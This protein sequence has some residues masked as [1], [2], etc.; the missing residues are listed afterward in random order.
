MGPFFIVVV[1]IFL[2]MNLRIVKPV[3]ITGDSGEEKSLDISKKKEK[4]N[5]K[6]KIESQN[7]KNFTLN[8][9]DNE[10]SVTFN[11]LIFL[12]SRLIKLQSK[13]NSKNINDI[14]NVSFLNDKVILKFKNESS[15]KKGTFIITFLEGSVQDRNGN[16]IDDFSIIFSTNNILNKHVLKGKVLDLMT[17]Q[18]LKN[19]YVF[20]YKVSEDDLKNKVSSR[21][22][23]NN[24]K[25]EYFSKTDIL[26]NYSF[27]N[28]SKGIYFLC[29]GEIDKEN[30]MSDPNKHKYGFSPR[31]IKID[32]KNNAIEQ[33]IFILNSLLNEFTILN[34]SI[35]NNK[36]IIETNDF[37]SEFN[38]DIKDNLL[39][40]Y[41]KYSEL[42]KKSVQISDNKKI[43]IDNNI[44]NLIS[45]DFLPC[46]LTI[47]SIN[48][49][50]I[51]KDIILK[52]NNSAFN[53]TDDDDDD[54]DDFYNEP[55][56]N[57]NSQEFE[58]KALSQDLSID[59]LF[60]FN[61]I[62]KKNVFAT[63]KTKF[64]IIISD[65]YGLVKTPFTDF[66]IIEEYN[67]IHI[68]TNK[69]LQDI[70]NDI[71]NN[72]DKFNVLSKNDINVVIFVD[73]DA[74]TYSDFTKNKDNISTFSFLRSFSSL[75]VSF[76]IKA[77]HFKLQLL[78][79]KYD[80]IKEIS[81]K[82]VQDRDNIT[83]EKVKDGKYFLRYFYWNNSAD[84]NKKNIWNSGNINKNIPND[85]VELYKK[86]IFV[87]S[88]SL[89]EKIIIE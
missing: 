62:T 76:K 29:A 6:L 66:E 68:K 61:I 59:S 75:D 4:D 40:K 30:F 10:I 27:E 78:N 54:Y 69:K 55:T 34:E 15:K 5:E 58:I 3:S 77:D 35:I 21:N 42:L 88:Y 73:K 24:N 33:N 11:K 22:I 7:P 87:K 26:G 28:L 8:F 63:D 65:S 43:E 13:D 23:I 83:F 47:K 52:F 70:I 86:D 41:S 49:E 17:K 82:F 19:I 12:N 80:V 36:Y 72:D 31:F 16:F 85:P 38:I 32:D 46:K 39:I 1:P 57:K 48:D 44:L 37:I 25:P 50:K 9:K 45:S 67:N 14:F 81:D 60:D 2:L 71:I 56:N 20:L 53:D 74:I 51:E 64:K 84:S 18:E 89:N 79:E